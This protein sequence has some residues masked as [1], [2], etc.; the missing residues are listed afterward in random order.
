MAKQLDADLKKLLTKQD[1]QEV[2]TEGRA[3]AR[4]KHTDDLAVGCRNALRLLLGRGGLRAGGVADEGPLTGVALDQRVVN[5]K[6][7][8]L[9]HCDP[10]D[11]VGGLKLSFRRKLHSGREGAG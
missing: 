11:A 2:L 8:R 5:E 1:A 10:A 6:I 4:H 9:L 3:E 7:H